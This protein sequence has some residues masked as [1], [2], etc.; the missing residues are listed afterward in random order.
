[1]AT[2][3]DYLHWRGDITLDIAPF[4]AADDLVMARIAYIPFEDVVEFNDPIMVGEACRKLL[5]KEDVNVRIS[6][7]EDIEF[8]QL[9]MDSPR[10]SSM[11]LSRYVSRLDA[12]KEKQF[13]A[14]TIDVDEHLRYIAYRGTDNTLTGWKEDFNM[15]FMHC[16]PSQLE[17]AAYLDGAYVQDK[18]YRL[19]G[20]S[21]GGNL[22][23]FAA[24]QANPVV[25]EKIDA[26][27]SFDGPG[28][29]KHILASDGYRAICRKIVSIVPQTSI[30]GMMLDH[31]AE[32]TIIHST[33]SGLM[34]HDMYSWQMRRD[35]FEYLETVTST[36]RFIDNTLR[37]WLEA[38]PPA[39]REAFVDSL[40]YLLE[41]VQEEK[42]EDGNVSRYRM[43]KKGL[44][45]LRQM[46]PELRAPLTQATK[47][48]FLCMQN[49]AKLVLRQR[50]QAQQM[51]VTE[52]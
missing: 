42:D 3:L 44:K 33:Q 1:M 28:F 24:A 19:S 49:N 14:I 50:K 22:A 6:R 18:H 51:T 9:L 35:G 11:H 52:E 34:Q 43:V 45:L 29:H 48:L 12:Q 13:A 32:Y 39:Q 4:C 8:L 17:A 10:F 36:S 21:K 2:L 15:S 7:K 38:Q 47:V 41:N 16:V 26:I 25:Q 31:G 37:D 27:Y 20:H 30:I 23:V 46:D 5:L 40:F